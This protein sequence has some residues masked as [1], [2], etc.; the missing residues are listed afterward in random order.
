LTVPGLL[1]ADVQ[2]DIVYVP[3]STPCLRG[4]LPEIQILQSRYHEYIE[5]ELRETRHNSVVLIIRQSP[6]NKIATFPVRY[7]KL[8][9]KELDRLVANTNLKLEVFDDKDNVS[10]ADTLKMFHR[11][12][13]IV[14]LHGA[15]LTNMI[16]AKPGTYVVEMLCQQPETSLRFVHA[17][18]CARKS[19]P[20]CTLEWMSA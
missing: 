16:H 5:Q 2:A 8:M 20:C 7:T 6:F 13:L 4:M 9:R 3:K 12:R 1:E 14:G 11:A 18:Q 10:F 17:D 19:L 15:G